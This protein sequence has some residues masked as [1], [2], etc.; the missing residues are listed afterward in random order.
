MEKEQI[1]MKASR[2]LIIGI[3]GT[4]KTTLAR[5]LSGFLKIPITYYDEFVWEENWKEVNEK[6]VE[7]KL[8]EVIKREKWIIEG[9]IS[10]AAQ[11]K[12]KNADLILYLDYS[13]FR[14]TLGGLK[15]WWQYRGKIRPEMA[16]G[17]V[18]RFDLK[19]LLVMLK[20]AE[21]E[22]IENEVKNFESKIIRLK[23]PKETGNFFIKYFKK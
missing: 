2:I 15:R 1:F 4:G 12:L 3:S 22:E 13:R 20:R 9:F 10:P 6:I 17:C 5:K 21:R 16:P 8:E 19:Y 14:A 11:S 18:E 7:K 23:S